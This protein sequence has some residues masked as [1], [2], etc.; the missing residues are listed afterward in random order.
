MGPTTAL[1]ATGLFAVLALV[2][3]AQD[4]SIVLP[5]GNAEIEE[6]VAAAAQSARLLRGEDPQ[7]QRQTLT[8][9]TLNVFRGRNTPHCVT[10][11]EGP[12]DRVIAV[13][14]YFPRPGVVFTPEERLGF[15]GRRG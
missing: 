3:V 8:P 6:T 7:M 5:P 11:V 13:F 14:S 12:V 10:P 4:V 9:G 1:C 2:A 15:Y